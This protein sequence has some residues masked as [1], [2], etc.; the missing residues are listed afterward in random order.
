MTISSR[1]PEGDSN[2]CPICRHSVRLEPS[3][4]T[5][6]A[7]CPSCGHLLWFHDNVLAPEPGIAD[8]WSAKEAVLT[9]GVRLFGPAPHSIRAALDRLA[10]SK[11]EKVEL[12][13]LARAEN[14]PQ[15]LAIIKTGFC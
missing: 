7:P 1:T 12:T 13:T 5:R 6:D 8:K 2:R 15:L 3:I 10:P 14:W 9:L 4:D 11:F